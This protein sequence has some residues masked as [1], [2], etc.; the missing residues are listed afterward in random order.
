M[1]W[2]RF[3][4]AALL[5]AA[6]VPAQQPASNPLLDI[7]AP[8][9]FDRIRAEHVGPAVEELLAEA[10]KEVET[11]ATGSGKLTFENT[12]LALDDMGDKLD[13]AM[14][15][16]RHLDS[17][18]SNVE[19]RAALSRAMPQVTAFRSSVSLD[20]RVW[21]RIKKYAGTREA[22]ALTGNRKRLLELTL[23]RFRR[24]GAD[25]DEA[26]KKRL[27]E[28][29]VELT[30]A[31]K[32]FSDN[33]LESTDAFDLVITD[34]AK[35]AGL[36]ET[37]RTNARQAAK[38]KGVEGWRF[39]L[40]A[41]STGAVLGYLD[42]PAIRE[43][44][45]RASIT[46]AKSGRW[47]NGPLIQRLIELRRERA[48]LLGYRDWADY[49]TENRMAGS[50]AKVREFLATLEKK[51]RSAF[52]RER[53]ELLAF[54]RSLEGPQA[55]ALAPSE[56]AYYS[57]K[58]RQSRYDL[59][60]ETLR[61]YFVFD[62]VLKGLFEIS[63]RLY[64][65]RFTKIPNAPVW[66]PAAEYFEVRDG[67]G[68]LLGYFYADFYARAGKHS[69]A[70]SNTLISRRP[71]RP[72]VGIIIGN[73]TPPAGGRPA[74]LTHGEATVVFHEFGHLL[75][76]L[77]NRVPEDGL[78]RPVWDFI[79]LPSQIMENFTWDRQ[80]LDLFARHYQTG[81]R[82]PD[83]LYR[84]MIAARNFNAA[85]MQMAQLGYGTV[86]LQLH[87][88]YDPARDGAPTPYARA[89]MQRFSSTELPPEYAQVNRF[90]HL[91]AGGYS[92]GYYSYKWAEVLEA[93]A[94]T[95]FQKEG[96]LNPK[97][98]ME[99]RHKIL[100]RGNSADAAQLFRDFMGRDPDPDAL[101]VRSGL[102]KK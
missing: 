19:L 68:S 1:F 87:T 84:R 64:G 26:S 44:I 45:Y 93:D 42:D 52:E 83:D 78:R 98:G 12:I 89:I 37:A 49:M 15:A 29:S 57:R 46:V 14:S 16:A 40:Q 25:L 66:H 102:L 28:I 36:T 23:K 20:P 51:T 69:G 18:V 67:D 4:A 79:E 56:A 60:P 32:Q 34:E 75:E 70:W 31:S 22:R 39:T 24:N 99:F 8:I 54:R 95:R 2:F 11:Y 47:D 101:L 43:K 35:L 77:L 33:A 17:V 74:L 71:G 7:K 3:A 82:I 9:P 81:E 50:G 65:I 62:N 55:P 13:L 92:A 61:P 90:A 27:R 48:K 80:C 53:G 6:T 38:E 63:G 59:D 58:L 88:V 94:F 91:F 72:P 41:P 73:A 10:R 96:V 76:Q 21:A 97:V 85:H 30:K 5:A 86:D 100:E